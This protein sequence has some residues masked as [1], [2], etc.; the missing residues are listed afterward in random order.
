MHPLSISQSDV[1]TDALAAA[2]A[3]VVERCVDQLPVDPMRRAKALAQAADA[4]LVLSSDELVALGVKGVESFVD[5]DHAYGYC[6]R[7]HRQRNRTL[8]TVER[9]LI[10]RTLPL[11][12]TLSRQVGFGMGIEACLD[13]APVG[14]GAQIFA[15]NSL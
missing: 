14:V 15:V 11:A 8:W 4:S 9:S 13:L 7:R 5:G 6:F 10:H 1:N 12:K 3:T 2:L